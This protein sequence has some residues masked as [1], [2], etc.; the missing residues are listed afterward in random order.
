MISN[1][2]AKG[3]PRAKKHMD[4]ASSEVTRYTS[5]CTARV[6]VITI[7]VAATATPAEKKNA[8]SIRYS[9][10]GSWQQALDVDRLGFILRSALGL[11]R[12]G[13]ARNAVEVVVG[14]LAGARDHQVFLL[15]HQVL[16]LELGQLEVGR[17]LDRRGGAG[18]LTQ[19]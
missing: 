16:A 11:A 3:A 8:N 7:R 18:L 2:P 15:V 14:I 13:Q 17:Q 12:N 9:S 4:T 10:H 5:A 19:A 6:L 1:T